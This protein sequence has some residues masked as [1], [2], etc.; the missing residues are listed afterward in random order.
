MNIETETYFTGTNDIALSQ[1]NISN[2]ANILGEL[3]QENVV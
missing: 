1:V 2:I 3:F